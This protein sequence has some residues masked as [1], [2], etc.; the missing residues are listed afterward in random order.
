MATHRHIRPQHSTSD[1]SNVLL[2]LPTMLFSTILLSTL[3]CVQAAF[4][5]PTV[6]AR[7]VKPVT[8]FDV[9]DSF[10]NA[11]PVFTSVDHFLPQITADSSASKDSL[12][13]PVCPFLSLFH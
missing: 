7:Q 4:A 5:A 2:T 11:S 12:F 1:P 8:V 13:L 6:Q 9:T 10:H 3:V